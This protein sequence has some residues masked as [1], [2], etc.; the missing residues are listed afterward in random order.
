MH[1]MQVVQTLHQTDTGPRALICQWANPNACTCLKRNTRASLRLLTS[2]VCNRCTA[3]T[4]NLWQLPVISLPTS[5]SHRTR[6]ERSNCGCTLPIHIRLPISKLSV[7]SLPSEASW[8][9]APLCPWT[10]WTIATGNV[11]VQRTSI[12][13]PI[14]IE[15]RFRLPWRRARASFEQELAA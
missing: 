3:Y 14:S 13:F 6:A 9:C 2:M 11:N 8:T 7:V 5:E 1:E 15:Y 10:V 12:S 4:G